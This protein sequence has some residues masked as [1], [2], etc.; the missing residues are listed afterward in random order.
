MTEG[1]SVNFFLTGS[2]KIVKNEEVLLHLEYL[3]TRADNGGF[4]SLEFGQLSR[5]LMERPMPAQISRRFVNCLV[6]HHPVQGDFTTLFMI[7][8]YLFFFFST[9]CYNIAERHHYSGSDLVDLVLWVLGDESNI[10][11]FIVSSILQ[12]VNLCLEYDLV[13]VRAPLSHICI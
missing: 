12:I 10:S 3:E 9:K 2:G 5:V 8:F 13:N 7:C 6:P 4:S 1:Q 11:K